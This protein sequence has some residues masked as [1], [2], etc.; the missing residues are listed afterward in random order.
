MELVVRSVIV[1]ELTDS[2]LML[3]LI[4]ATRVVPSLVL[5]VV[6]GVLADR[7]D[8]RVVLMVSQG[9]NGLSGLTLGILFVLGVAQPWHFAVMAFVE[10]AIGAV[11]QPA[12]QA[13]VASVVERRHLLNAVAL[14]SSN[15]RIARM[16]APILAGAI[17]ALAGPASALFLEAGLYLIAAV[18]ISR[19]RFHAPVRLDAGATG[20]EEGSH[21]RSGDRAAGRGGRRWASF[22]EELRGYGYL[23]QNAVVG[24]LV[25]LGLAPTVFSLSNNTMAPVFAKDVLDMGPGGAGLLLSAPG[26]GSV[27]AI[28]L[29]ASAGDMKRKG[30]ISL[31]ALL[32]MAV[33]LILF[34]LSSW[35]W[36]SLVMLAIHGFGQAAYQT[37][38]HT[39]VQ[40]HT[41]D[42]YR[43]RVMA[44]YQMDRSLH[45]LGVVLTAAIAEFWGP[46]LAI[47]FN[48]LAC[49]GALLLVAT[50][51]RVIR[52]LD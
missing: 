22:A 34:G 27:V 46:Q 41:P 15:Q 4:N 13:M 12:R 50:R 31:A 11:Q 48:G 38:N 32:L 17:I 44:V 7:M 26:I 42:E 36:L 18:A 6:G 51:S 16:I 49:I 37:T 14:N 45:P 2:A 28:I 43:G 9:V 24:W 30:L 35:L 47:V 1:Y 10:G 52:T 8:R 29:L 23:R 25:V 20:R 19:V 5:G 3:G 33:T 21:S 39:L 40:L